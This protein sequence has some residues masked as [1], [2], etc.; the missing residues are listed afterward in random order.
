MT[1]PRESARLVV[2]VPGAW[3]DNVG[4]FVFRYRDYIVPVAL[5]AVLVLVRPDEPF[6]SA[7]WNT[8]AD[9][10][11][12]LI[13]L[14]GQAWRV[15][16]IGLAYIQRGGAQKSLSAPTLVIEGVYAHCRN[17]MYIGDFLL[18]LGLCVIYNSVW[19][20][21][22]ALPVVALSLWAMVVAEERYLSERFGAAYADY[23]RRVNRFV[24]DLRGWRQT[25]RG[26]RFDWR[27]VL[28]K[29]YGTTFAWL[30]GAFVLLAWE[31][32]ARSGWSAAEPTLL[33]LAVLYAPIPLLYG[34]VRWLK[35]SGRLRS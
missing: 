6:R 2:A 34:I 24:P 4:R 26:L 22:A 11:G 28:R 10:V 16:V 32:V 15:L 13:A 1:A 31:R 21:A 14:A 18:F 27:R 3:L 7:S 8:I 23:C 30:S 5:L 25:M 35:L 9:I 12:L 17:P 19:V 20:Y 29:E 33:A